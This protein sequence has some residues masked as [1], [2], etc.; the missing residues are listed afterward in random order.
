MGHNFHYVIYPVNKDK[1][2]YNFIGI[3]KYQL[4]AKELENYSLF[5]KKLSFK[6]LKIKYKMNF[7][8]ISRKN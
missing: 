2:N 7:Q 5:K 3:L 4:T 8:L 6:A 1:E